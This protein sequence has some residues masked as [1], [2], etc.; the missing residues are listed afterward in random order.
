MPAIAERDERIQIGPDRFYQRRTGNA[1]HPERVSLA[2]LRDLQRDIGSY[3][4]AA[5]FQQNPIPA[6]GNMVLAEWLREHDPEFDPFAT[7]G[8]IIQ[9]WD[10]ASKDGIDNDWSVCVTAHVQG[11]HVRIIHVFRRKLKF[12]DLLRHGVRLAHEH[13]AQTILIEDQS[14]GIQLIQA[15]RVHPSIGDAS[16]LAQRPETDKAARLSSVCSIIEEGEVT[17]PSDASWLGLFKTELLAFPNGRHDD[18]VDAFAQLLSFARSRFMQPPI[19]PA[20]V[21]SFPVHIPRPGY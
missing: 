8:H 18:Q 13:H 15:L 16:I 4:F 6:K 2:T 17:L 14:S 20:L 3:N 21:L 10:T 11:R 7:K 5:Q 9:A 19:K 12:P 1:L